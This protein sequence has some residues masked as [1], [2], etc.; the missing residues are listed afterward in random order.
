MLMLDDREIK[1]ISKKIHEP[2]MTPHIKFISPENAESPQLKRMYRR[3]SKERTS[4]ANI[5]QSQSLNPDA[6]KAHLDLY[7]NTVYKSSSE[8]SRR[9]RELI[10]TVVSF[11]NS[12][13]YCITHHY[14]ALLA[15]WPDA[16]QPPFLVS[17]DAASVLTQREYAIVNYSIKLTMAPHSC[18][19]KE[20]RTLKNLKLSDVAI[21]DV[22]LIISYFNFVNRLALGTGCPLENQT[23]R[24]YNY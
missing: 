23:E 4:V 9:E 1:Q 12:C 10:A 15:H 20:I 16:P 8:L 24:N 19:K 2:P 21:L 13:K 22:I 7:M 6:M 11:V 18:G 5:H 17:E 14:E 3:V